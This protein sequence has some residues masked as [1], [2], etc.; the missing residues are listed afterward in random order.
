MARVKKLEGFTIM[1]SL[2]AMIIV[3]SSFGMA[4]MVYVN[5]MQFNREPEKIHANRAIDAMIEQTLLQKSFL[6]EHFSNEIFD[7][8]KT[9]KAYEGANNLDEL[10]I[11]VYDK[12][13]R[14]I[15]SRKLLVRT[16]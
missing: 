4:S 14:L 2:V 7:I 10:C 13:K 1:E 9:L 15:T 3:A 5:C 6:N 11:K 8:D 12:E 16:Q